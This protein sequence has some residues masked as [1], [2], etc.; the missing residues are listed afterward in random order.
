MIV[1]SPKVN[2]D[3]LI[4]SP[5]FS[6]T[7]QFNHNF[8][9]GFTPT[10]VAS[11]LDTHR[12]PGSF[13]DFMFRPSPTDH[14]SRV[15][16]NAKMDKIVDNLKAEIQHNSTHLGSEQGSGNK[17]MNL[18]IDL[19]NNT[20]TPAPPTKSS[21]GFKFPRMGDLLQSPNSSFLPRKKM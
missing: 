21:V 6:T 12:G 1:D 13:D 7:H 4:L 2:P 20:Y 9:R 8:F 19:I 5:L 15:D 10:S 14:V 11:K 18:D 3:T 16:F 17:G